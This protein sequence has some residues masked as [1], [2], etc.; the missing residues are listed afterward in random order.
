[1]P[2]ALLL[3]AA[4]HVFGIVP[5]NLSAANRLYPTYRHFSRNASPEIRVTGEMGTS[6]EFD[7]GP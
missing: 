4:A 2:S 1:M 3:T 5:K 6:P 7:A